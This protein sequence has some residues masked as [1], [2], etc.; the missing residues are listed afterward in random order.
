MSRTLALEAVEKIGETVTLK[1]WVNTRRDHGKIV[2]IDLRD[3]SGLIQVVL[4]PQIASDFRSEDVVAITGMVKARPEKLVNPKLVTGTIEVEASSA[5][6][7]S[8]SA[9]MPFDMGN[10]DLEVELPTLL[11]YR[12]L[13]LRHPKV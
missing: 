6:I 11:D 13:T 5:E 8:K 12:S 3:R 9:E 2:F 4:T 7:L 1:G 10:V